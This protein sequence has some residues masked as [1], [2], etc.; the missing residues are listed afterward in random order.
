MTFVNYVNYLK[1]KVI[2]TVLRSCF[3]CFFSSLPLQFLSKMQ[4][5][6]ACTWVSILPTSVVT[7]HVFTSY[8]IYFIL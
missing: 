5:N 2:F 3:F 7:A 4:F 1:K 8:F 6:N